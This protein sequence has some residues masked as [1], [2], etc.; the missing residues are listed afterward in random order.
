M[1]NRKPL[2]R[3]GDWEL[4]QNLPPR[5]QQ[6]VNDPALFAFIGA[7]GLVMLTSFVAFLLGLAQE[8][9]KARDRRKQ[10]GN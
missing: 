1:A 4:G 6:M 7:L 8:S 5:A 10:G 9:Q 3:A 2:V